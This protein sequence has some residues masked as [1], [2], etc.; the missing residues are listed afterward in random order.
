MQTSR[1]VAALVVALM[2]TGGFACGSEGGSDADGDGLTVAV[3][4]D[5]PG[6]GLKGP[7]GEYRG[8]DI[9]VATY[10]AKRLGVD[11]DK[12]EWKATVPAERENMLVRGDV[13]LVVA[14]YSITEERKRKIS[15]AGPYFLAHQDLLIRADDTAI[16]DARDLNSRKL[17]SVTG[18]TSAQNIKQDLAPKADLQEFSSPTECL[19][20]L[21]N[22]V[23]DALTNDD[24]VL[25]GFAAQRAHRGKFKLAGLQLSDE[26]Y[27]IGIAKGDTEMRD[28]VNEALRAMV[29]DR[30]W[31]RS[32][33]RNFGPAHFDHEPAPKITETG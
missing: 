1:K 22:K 9:D 25:A 33:R 32:V 30:S 16:K 24:A 4:D 11:K 3:R 6:I 17:C 28:K 14:S 23:V 2:V 8:F 27:G 18:S 29:A 19:T 7:D 5:V 15:F 20:G 13:D 31:D 21:E 12:I 10:V 26:R